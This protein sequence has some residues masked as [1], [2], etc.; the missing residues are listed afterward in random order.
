M[1]TPRAAWASGEMLAFDLETTGV[2]VDTARIVSF[3]VVHIIPGDHPQVLTETVNP[4]VEIPEGASKVHGITTEYARE[5]GLAPRHALTLITELLEQADESV[6]IIIYNA[7]YDLSVLN[8]EIG[9]YFER[10]SFDGLIERLNVV[11]PLV[12]DKQ[13]NRFVR[14]KG[15]RRLVATCARYGIDLPEKDAHAADADAL[16]AARLAWKI[17]EHRDVVRL[18]LKDLHARQKVWHRGQSRSYADYLE[19]QG[20]NEDAARVR[21]EAEHWPVRPV[22]AVSTIQI[23]QPATDAE[24]VTP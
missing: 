21:A 9:R 7:P 22:P 5:F 6:P 3:A 18:S 23:D 2:D 13:V 24:R 11:D 17:A 16:A 4:G 20:K 14:G 1:S 8:R 19:R 12:I 10:A 15:G